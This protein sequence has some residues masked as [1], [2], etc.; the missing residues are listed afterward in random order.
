M[1]EV[2]KEKKSLLQTLFGK[3]ETE[4]KL[5]VTEESD[6]GNPFDFKHEMKITVDSETGKLKGVPKEWEKTIREAGLTVDEIEQNADLIGGAMD[7]LKSRT[8]KTT[9]SSKVNNTDKNSSKK[10][11]R[12]NDFLDPEEPKKVFKK[13]KLLDEGNYGVV[14]KGQFKKNKQACAIKIIVNKHLTIRKSPKIQKWKH[15]KQKLE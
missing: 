1:S 5:I 7:L 14:Y 11:K 9:T 13:S 15:W 8:D 4:E 12:L 2:K 6:I 3:K 10:K